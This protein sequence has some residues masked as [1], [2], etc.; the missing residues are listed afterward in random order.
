VGVQHCDVVV[1]GGGPGGSTAAALLAE[2]GRKVI[3]LEK[4]VHPRFHIG[5]SLLPA[6]LPLLDRLGVREQV[7]AIGMP[8][9]G[10][11][12]ISPD[13]D[14]A[15]ALR[16]TDAWDKSLAGAYQ[17]RR[18]VFDHLLLRNAARKGATV[19]QGRCA[20]QV[21]FSEHFGGA[22]VQS[23][24]PGGALQEWQ[25]R[26]LIDASGRETFLGNRFRIKQKNPHHASAAV[27]GH[28]VDAERLAGSREGDITIFWFE[29][30]WFWF[31]PLADGT[32]SVG[33]VCWP[34]YL[35]SRKKPVPAFFADTIALCP[36]LASR[37]AKA[38][39]VDDVHTTGNYSYS[40]TRAH[41]G[42]EQASY[43]MVGDAFAFIDPVF[44]SGVFLAMNSAFLAVDAVATCLDQPA[45]T[46]RALQA[47]ERLLRKGP[48][49]FSWFIERMTY[50]AMRELFMYPRNPL[51]VREAVMSIL[52]GDLYRGTP[53]KPSLIAFKSFF[54]MNLM[55]N[56]LAALRNR[57]RRKS[58]IRDL[59]L[60]VDA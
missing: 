26:M 25:G 31:I 47:Y 59:P 36:R 10:V 4:D 21:T 23:V 7:Q 2:Q 50:P 9:W 12:F 41:G 14:H 39:R 30:G 8:K 60:A 52:A 46:S 43:V 22:R 56:P 17:V 29:H 42:A 58:I 24:G 33:A 27:Y 20:R 13:H 37:L 57:R 11:E 51:R 44:S 48:R 6:N 34:Y 32:T 15:S 49:E 1:I 16:F 55:K 45:Q 40:C 5:E 38:T 53:Y 3:L 18:S 19:L 54:Y 28:F 35:K